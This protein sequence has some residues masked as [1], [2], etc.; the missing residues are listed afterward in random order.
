MRRTRFMTWFFLV[1]SLAFFCVRDF[2]RALEAPAFVLLPS[3]YWSGEF[4]AA[5]TAEEGRAGISSL[6]FF[7]LK[8][9]TARMLERLY[10]LERYVTPQGLLQMAQDADKRGDGQ[11]VAFAALHLPMEGLREEILRLTDRAVALDPRQTWLFFSLAY[12]F[13]SQWWSS[14]IT[15]LL[16]ARLDKL[17]AWDSSNALPHLIR[18]EMIRSSR[19]ENWAT[20]GSDKSKMKKVFAQDREWQREMEAAFSQPRYESYSLERFALERKIMMQRGWNH[21]M[22][23]TFLLNNQASLNILPVR[24]YANLIVNNI[25]ADAETAGRL[26]KALRNYRMVARF[27]QR[28]RLQGHTVLEE[29]YG[30]GI[31]KIANDRLVPALKK[32]GK[33]AESEAE[34]YPYRQWKKDIETLRNNPLSKS[35]NRD[36]SVLL[37]NLAAGLTWVFL[38]LTLICLVYV[39]AKQWI[40]KETKG[41]LHEFMTVAE[42]YFPIL[43]FVSCLGLY[44]ADAPFAQNFSSYMRTNEPILEFERFSANSFPGPGWDWYNRALPLEDPFQNYVPYALSGV[45]V[46]TVVMV[47]AQ[48]RW[49]RLEPVPSARGVAAEPISIKN[50]DLAVYLLIAVIGSV[51]VGA[52]RLWWGMLIFELF[53]A[54]L[55]AVTL[56]VTSAYVRLSKTRQKYP[57]RATMSALGSY[58]LVLIMA[59]LSGVAGALWVELATRSAKLNADDEWA[60][61]LGMLPFAVGGTVGAARMR[62]RAVVLTLW[63]LFTLLL[64]Y[65]FH[66]M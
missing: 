56:W 19:W 4:G 61:A 52:S 48:R 63:W 58:V 65:L 29:L 21:P 44:L 12:R 47:L 8:R 5:R 6:R 10:T 64:A 1:L 42:N 55:V 53:V 26:E 39:N 27:G 20:A 31:E 2:R 60:L 57:W 32:A 3:D 33:E 50:A 16:R 24:E 51:T 49:T 11:F 14:R 37:V 54:L 25:G 30:V 46:L 22:V 9:G 62:H 59:L 43:L 41:R 35:T 15:G 13:R 23:A 28:M 17:Q 45:V 36:W 38:A 18:A 66:N 7:L 40:R 34:D